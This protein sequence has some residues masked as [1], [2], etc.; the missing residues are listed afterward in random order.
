MDDIDTID[1]DTPLSAVFALLSDEY[2]EKIIIAGFIDIDTI[3]ITKRGSTRSMCIAFYHDTPDELTAV[4][5]DERYE[6]YAVI[7]Q[8]NTE[9]FTPEDMA[10]YIEKCFE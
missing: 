7:I 5:S 2:E 9:D 4:W 8:L 10:A 6:D 1:M 3:V